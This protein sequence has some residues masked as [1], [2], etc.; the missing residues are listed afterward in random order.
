MTL[1]GVRLL[2]ETETTCL[3]ECSVVF[4]IHLSNDTIISREIWWTPNG[5][6]SYS[7][8]NIARL[9]LEARVQVFEEANRLYNTNVSFKQP[10][11][12]PIY[13]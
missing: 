11:N 7:S 6:E 3:L 5:S 13:F 8:Y 9:L 1:K 12:I 4:S 2:A 10:R